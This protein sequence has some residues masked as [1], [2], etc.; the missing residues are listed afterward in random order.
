MFYC[1]FL[2]WPYRYQHVSGRER[3]WPFCVN[4]SVC[5]TH[6]H[7]YLL[8]GASVL[9]NGTYTYLLCSVEKLYEKA[10]SIY[11]WRDT[12]VLS[13]LSSGQSKSRKS[14]S[15]LPMHHTSASG[16]QDAAVLSRQHCVI[17]SDALS[18][19][20]SVLVDLEGVS[21]PPLLVFVP[22]Y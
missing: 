16:V 2:I 4:T 8:K 5:Y 12:A 18:P 1:K 13:I 7:S 11:M 17:F 14:F 20:N 10:K 15:Q 3:N 22:W 9:V 19:G 21:Y 6:F